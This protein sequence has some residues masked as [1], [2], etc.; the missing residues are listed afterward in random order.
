MNRNIL[1][2]ALALALLVASPAAAQTVSWN[3]DPAS[4]LGPNVW[5]TLTFP[6]AT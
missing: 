5:G 6:F 1:A 2:R 4:A 3:H